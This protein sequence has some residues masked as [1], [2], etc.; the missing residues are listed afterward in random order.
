MGVLEAVDELSCLFHV[1]S[2]TPSDL[3]WMI[4]SVGLDFTLVSGP[5][6]LADAF[7]D[8]AARCTAAVEDGPSRAR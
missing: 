4:T 7:R 3:V 8:Q 5:D 2:E 6:G 1:G